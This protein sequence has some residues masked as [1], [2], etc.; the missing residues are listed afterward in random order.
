LYERALGRVFDAGIQLDACLRQLGQLEAASHAS[1]AYAEAY[2]HFAIPARVAAE[3][4]R[5]LGALTDAEHWAREAVR[6]APRW[7]GAYVTLARVL[8]AEGRRGD[9]LLAYDRAFE[10]EPGD[11]EAR[12]G[13]AALLAS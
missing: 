1:R 10:L 11:R 13:R 3:A 12:E 6:R 7:S 5:E 4:H 8:V 9:A 2:P